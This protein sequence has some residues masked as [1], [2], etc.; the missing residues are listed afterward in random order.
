MNSW[1]VSDEQS[2]SPAGGPRQTRLA[3][4]HDEARA[5]AN[6]RKAPIGVASSAP[7]ICGSRGSCPLNGDAV[8]TVLRY[9]ESNPVGGTRRDGRGFFLVLRHRS[10][11]S[12]GGAAVS[13][14]NPRS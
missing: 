7:G 6:T 12:G 8:W 14:A 3:G 5:V 1:A 4:A 2:R 10:L 11:W 9:L 13:V